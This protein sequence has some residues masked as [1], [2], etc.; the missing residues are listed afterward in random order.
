MELA[1]IPGYNEAIADAAAEEMRL[2]DRAFLDLPEQICGIQVRPLTPRLCGILFSIKNPLLCGGK[3]NPVSESEQIL[4]FLWVVSPRFSRS[5]DAARIAFIAEHS[6]QLKLPDA[7]NET[8]AFLDR[9]LFDAPPGARQKNAVVN[10]SWIAS[11]N[12][13]IA[14]KYGWQ[15]E[16]LDAHGEPVIGAGIMDKPLPRLFQYLREIQADGGSMPAF[17]PLQDKATQRIVREW[18][19]AEM[20]KKEEDAP[21]N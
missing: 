14:E 18:H 11:L 6:L 2:R 21:C 15:D 16:V 7:L 19:A 12:H 13:R 9:M 4:M 8:Y 10:T 20:A 5:D 3:W 1:K 17:N